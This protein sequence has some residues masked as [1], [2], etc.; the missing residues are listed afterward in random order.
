MERID[1]LKVF[2]LSD[3]STAPA[4]KGSQLVKILSILE[5]HLMDKTAINDCLRDFIEDHSS[6]NKLYHEEDK[7]IAVYQTKMFITWEK[8]TLES[9]KHRITPITPLYM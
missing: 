4:C 2:L 6:W 1:E 7:R 9:I 5:L 8:P 3:Y